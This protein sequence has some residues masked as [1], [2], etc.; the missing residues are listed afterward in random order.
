MQRH[1]TKCQCCLSLILSDRITPAQIKRKVKIGS[2]LLFMQTT[3]IPKSDGQINGWLKREGGVDPRS[4][5]PFII[6]AHIHLHSSSMSI[7]RIGRQTK[8]FYDK[9]RKDGGHLSTV[10]CLPDEPFPNA[11]CQCAIF[12]AMI[13]ECRNLI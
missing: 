6:F 1:L 7:L 3:K 4:I 10:C 8:G 11:V 13:D 9:Y 5:Y 2:F 12:L